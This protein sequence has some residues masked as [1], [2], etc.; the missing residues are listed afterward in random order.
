M[1]TS[2]WK[3]NSR[4]CARPEAQVS[5]PDLLACARLEVIVVH[6]ALRVL[7]HEEK[8]ALLPLRQRDTLVQLIVWRHGVEELSNLRSSLFAL[9]AA[10]AL[11]QARKTRRICVS[12]L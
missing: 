8:L 4:A 7:G 11:R 6:W 1:A 5:L 3:A 9:Y 12:F 2:D 10:G